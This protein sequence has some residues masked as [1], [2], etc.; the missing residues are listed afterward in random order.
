MPPVCQRDQKKLLIPLVGSRSR[1]S[2]LVRRLYYS[3]H[4]F[5]RTLADVSVV[6]GAITVG[7]KYAAGL[8]TLVCK[9]N[10]LSET[11]R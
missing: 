1:C 10:V 11:K 8:E 5:D 6:F 2:L 3:L 4:S 7:H 9:S